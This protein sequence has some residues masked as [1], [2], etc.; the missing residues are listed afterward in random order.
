M[1]DLRIRAARADDAADLLVCKRDAILAINHDAYDADQLAA[2]APDGRDLGAFETALDGDEYEVR[3]AERA[4]AIV[5]YAVLN[6]AS[7]TIDAVFVDPDH[8]R[9]GVGRQLVG[10][11]ETTASVAGLDTLSVAASLNARAFYA[12]LG[13]EPI[14]R[15]TRTF[16]DHSV[17]VVRMRRSLA[18]C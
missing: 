10:V 4:G 11:L 9:S 12:D 1:T 8:A 17:P 5:G 2:W 13:Y 7:G 3:V 18:A 16:D 15:T 6:R 14:E